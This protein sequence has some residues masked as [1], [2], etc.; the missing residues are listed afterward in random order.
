[1]K[2]IKTIEKIVSKISRLVS[3]ISFL[4]IVCMM[5][6][7]AAD[8]FLRKFF[9]NA[10]V[11]SYEMVQYLLMVVIFASFSYTQTTKKHVR[12]TIFLAKLP[13]RV[14]TLIN[15]L[16]EL[17]CA[18]GAAV[19]GYA[20]CLQGNYLVEKAWTSDVLRFPI[21][22]FY[23]FEGVMLFIFALVILTDALRYFFATADREYAEETFQEYS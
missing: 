23:Y 22:P 7:I 13:W 11:G 20:A 12:M 3:Y 17:L 5:L 9:S 1:M 18:A 8:V 14:H 16:W 10:I 21:A 15:G 19:M 2:T 4:G 6:L